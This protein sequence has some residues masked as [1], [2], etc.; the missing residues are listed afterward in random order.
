M[1]VSFVATDDDLLAEQ[2]KSRRDVEFYA[3][4]CS[5]PGQSKEDKG[6]LGLLP[7]TTNLLKERYEVGLLWRDDAR[8]IPNNFASALFQFMHWSRVW[9]EKQW[10][11]FL[12]RDHQ[13][14]TWKTFF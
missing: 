4:K 7:K 10:E 13:R 12:H 2:L 5:L 1:N 3:A 8:E 9:I 14:L 11:S 6:A